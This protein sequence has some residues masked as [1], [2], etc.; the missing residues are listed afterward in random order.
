VA[1]SAPPPGPSD[2]VFWQRLGFRGGVGQRHDDGPSTVDAICRTISSV[3]APDWVNVPI[4]I[5]GF[6]L[7]TT[8]ARVIGSPCCDQLATS[9]AG[10]A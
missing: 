2:E 10:R 4:S 7:A 3:K 8:S 6:T 9:S 1:T 5:V